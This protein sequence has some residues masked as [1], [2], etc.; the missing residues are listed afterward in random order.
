MRPSEDPM[1]DLKHPVAATVRL[2]G[3]EPRRLRAAAPRRDARKTAAWLIAAIATALSLP[4][5]AQTPN[6][7][8]LD[9][10]YGNICG[11]TKESAIEAIEA[12]FPDYKGLFE[13][14]DREV[15][16]IAPNRERP[17]W[18]TYRVKERRPESYKPAV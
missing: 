12:E 6:E 16:W 15:K 10:C 5:F 14:V 3:P 8:I 9:Y 17:L 18:F 1:P 2:V 11:P 7:E 13:E 4:S